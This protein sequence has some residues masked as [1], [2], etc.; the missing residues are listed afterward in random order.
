[1]GHNL[2]IISR[3]T[4]DSQHG[5]GSNV[6]YWFTPKRFLNGNLN[7]NGHLD[8]VS[9]DAKNNKMVFSGWNATNYSRL[10]T[11]HFLILFDTT[12]NKQVDSIKVTD[13]NGLVKR[14]DVTKAFPTI[15]NAE[16]SGFSYGFDMD[17]LTYGHNLCTS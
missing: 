11:N 16:Q 5:E 15:A 2:Q 8:G 12:A 4:D 17:K 9:V 10:E 13:K 7:N 1:M 14:D 3:Y 6:N